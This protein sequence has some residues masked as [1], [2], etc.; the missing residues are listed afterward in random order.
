MSLLAVPV[1]RPEVVEPESE[2]AEDSGPD[3]TA[4]TISAVGGTTDGDRFTIQWTT[5]EPADTWLDFET[6]GLVGDGNLVTSHSLSLRGSSGVTYTFRLQSADA[7]G[8]VA[9]S[10]LYSISL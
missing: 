10:G 5:D 8:N 3:T 2:P 9:T 7:A 4:P 1:P 6:Y